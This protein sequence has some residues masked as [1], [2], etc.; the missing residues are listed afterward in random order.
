[1]KLPSYQSHKIV[2]A[3]KIES[4][5]YEEESGPVTL[6]LGWLGSQQV[7][8]EWFQKFI[9]RPGGYFVQYGDGYQSYSPA[10]AFEN[11]YRPIDDKPPGDDPSADCAVQPFDHGQHER[12]LINAAALEAALRSNPAPADSSAILNDARKYAD[13]LSGST[14]VLVPAAPFVQP[15]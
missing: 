10:E 4:V 11:G 9:P 1:M 7:D 3:A 2:Q 6:K 13:F 12:Q 5:S 14:T 8:W 15:E